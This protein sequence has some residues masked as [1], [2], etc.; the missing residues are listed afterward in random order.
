TRTV[1]DGRSTA[2]TV[3][4]P[5]QQGYRA[6]PRV[7]EQARPAALTGRAAPSPPRELKDRRSIMVEA[8]EI[9]LDGRVLR[10]ETGKGANQAN[11]AVTVQMGD[12]VVLATATMS[13]TE[14]ENI[15]FFPLLCD[16]E[17]RMYAVGK[18]PGGFYKREGRPSERATLTSRL[19]DRPLRPL[20]PDGM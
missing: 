14:R 20:F 12:T 17:E 8:R 6:L 11:G 3:E 19:I 5:E 16:Y 18:L 1:D 10:V 13:A 4:L 9:D 2:A 7:G 15:D